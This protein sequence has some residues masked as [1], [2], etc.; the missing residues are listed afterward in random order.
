MS[1][2]FQAR[3]IKDFRD[4]REEDSPGFSSLD[5]K[6]LLGG[7]GR[8]FPKQHEHRTAWQL[9]PG[10]VSLSKKRGR[11]G[12]SMKESK[13]EVPQPCNPQQS[14][15]KLESQQLTGLGRKQE[16]RLALGPCSSAQGQSH[17]ALWRQNLGL[18]RGAVWVYMYMLKTLGKSLYPHL[19]C[20]QHHERHS[21]INV[22]TEEAE[23]RLER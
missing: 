9:R 21:H 19:G 22:I 16:L 18:L 8:L 7:W 2:R 4:S 14:S 12:E 17:A 3:Q 13:R 20:R 10:G 6:D 1:A 11:Y 15:A 23:S 5:L